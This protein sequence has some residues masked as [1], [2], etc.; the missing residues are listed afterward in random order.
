MPDSYDCAKLDLLFP[1]RLRCSKLYP[2]RFCCLRNLCSRSRR[3]HSF[4]PASRFTTA[5]QS[6][7]PFASLATEELDRCT[8]SL[9]LLSRLL[10]LLLPLRF[11]LSQCFQNIHES[12]GRISSHNS[13][14]I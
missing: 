3:H 11:F 7:G 9:Q 6:A 4:L 8:H 1:L 12:S 5:T 14:S 10:R 2:P 13:R